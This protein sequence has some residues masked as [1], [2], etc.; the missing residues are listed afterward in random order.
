MSISPPVVSSPHVEVAPDCRTCPPEGLPAGPEELQ[1]IG[2]VRPDPRFVKSRRIDVH[3]NS[4]DRHGEH[5]NVRKFVDRS[6]PDL[7]Q[8]ETFCADEDHL[9]SEEP[10]AQRGPIGMFPSRIDAAA[11]NPMSEL[12]ADLF[13]VCG[14]NECQRLGNP[15]KNRPTRP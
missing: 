13:H 15:R 7:F 6:S 8:I 1:T 14:G 4:I 11:R 3:V 2:K 9:F 12:N 10:I 5:P